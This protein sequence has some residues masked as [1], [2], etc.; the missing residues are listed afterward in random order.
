MWR[1]A[2]LIRLTRIDKEKFHN[3]N[4]NYYH[5]WNFSLSILVNLMCIKVAPLS[6]ENPEHSDTPKQARNT[7]K[8]TTTKEH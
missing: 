3:N 5:L 4:N 2:T 1:G 6:Y 8:T 7:F